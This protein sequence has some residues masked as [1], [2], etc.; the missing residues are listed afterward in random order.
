MISTL[1]KAIKARSRRLV[2]SCQPNNRWLAKSSANQISLARFGSTRGLTTWDPLVGHVFREFPN[3]V[4]RWGRFPQ[5][6]IIEK[7][8]FFWGG[9]QN[10]HSVIRTRVHSWS[11]KRFIMAAHTT[12]AKK[13]KLNILIFW[14]LFITNWM[15]H[16][17][18]S[19]RLW[20]LITVFRKRYAWAQWCALQDI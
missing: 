17:R 20:L 4:V 19:I 8:F 9:V 11:E 5:T 10:N 15:I 2:N 12:T 3:V 13:K 14:L 18:C 7:S 1:N 6:D 16:H